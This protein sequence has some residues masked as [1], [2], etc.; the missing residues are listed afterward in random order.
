[1]HVL[2][3]PN[4][5]MPTHACPRTLKPPTHTCLPLHP[6]PCPPPLQEWPAE[7]EGFLRNM[8]MPSGDLV[9]GWLSGGL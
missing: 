9:G 8:K 6:K 5:C 3:Y 7:L 1:M 2:G 4:P